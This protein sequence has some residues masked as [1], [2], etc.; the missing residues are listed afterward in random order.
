MVGQHAPFSPQAG[1]RCSPDSPFSPRRDFGAHKTA[2]SPPGGT[3]VLTRQ[4]LLPPGRSSVLTRHPLLPQA[5][6]GEGDEGG[7]GAGTA[8]MGWF[9]GSKAVET[10]ST[11]WQSPPARTRR[12]IYGIIPGV[13][14]GRLRHHVAANSFAW[15]H[16]RHGVD[17]NS[18]PLAQ[19]RHPLSVNSSPLAPTVLQNGTLAPQGSKPWATWEQ[20]PPGLPGPNPEGFA[21]E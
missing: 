19:G 15:G 18:F 1:V 11:R 13:S 20:S 21:H 5:G 17:A 16:H 4:P 3:S 8:S 2:P 9:L 12:V 7:N 6:E 10:A 14:A